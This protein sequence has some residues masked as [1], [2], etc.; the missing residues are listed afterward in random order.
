MAGIAFTSAYSQ[1]ATVTGL[2]ITTD[3]S[4]SLVTLDWTA[5][6]LALGVFDAYVVERQVGAA[7]WEEIGEQRDRDTPTFTDDQ[8]PAGVLVRYR[9]RVSI[10]ATGFDSEPLD[11]ETETVSQ[12]AVVVP[13]DPSLTRGGLYVQA[14]ATV[15][16]PWDVSFPRGLGAAF[17]RASEEPRPLG[18]MG[19]VWSLNL[20]VPYAHQDIADVVFEWQR[21][22]VVLKSPDG[23]VGW[24]RISG[25]GKTYHVAGRRTGSLTATEIAV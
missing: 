14:G 13:E 17:P 7:P 8:A 20:E 4:T 22:R 23:W 3:P 6:T 18:R 12:W 5:T 24:V 11:G 19:R 25:W 16:E 1:P 21:R 2:V 9:V 10:G 15:S